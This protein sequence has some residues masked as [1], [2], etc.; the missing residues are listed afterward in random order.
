MAGK[1]STR[2]P[3]QVSQAEV[4]RRWAVAFGRT[5][6]KRR[7][8]GWETVVDTPTYVERR[9]RGPHGVVAISTD[10]YARISR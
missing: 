5:Q 9:R 7:Y 3:A 8:E 6:P 10:L 4:R 1:G 2:R